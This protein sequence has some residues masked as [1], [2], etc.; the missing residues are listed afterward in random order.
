[1]A[2]EALER[3]PVGGIGA[4]EFA[5][6]SA[7]VHR[8]CGIVLGESKQLLVCSRLARRLRELGMESYGQY[9]DH[10]EGDGTENELARMVDLLTTNKTSFFRESA[11]FEFLSQQVIPELISRGEEVRV[12]SAACSS[13]EE[14][15]SLAMCLRDGL[16]EAR[17]GR[18][19]VLATDISKRMLERARQ[20][21][22]PREAVREVPREYQRR[23][24]VALPP[25]AKDE[26]RVVDELRAAVRVAR[27]NLL[28]D[29]PMQ[30]PFDV[31]FCRNVMIYFDRTTQAELVRRLSLV[32]RPGGY[33]FVG[34]SEGLHG[35]STKLSYV[36]PA[37]YRR[38]A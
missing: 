6:L 22:Y 37:V 13:G 10:V 32:L 34:H 16:G 3:A 9:L 18:F 7:M 35:V 27:L 12:W 38:A 17:A 1:M 31:V 25:P 11:H 14:P 26:V 24:L 28:E 2:R 4:A 15:Y 5:R 36:R 23:Y 33:L 30:G 8:L 29:W 19:R 21:V 20:A